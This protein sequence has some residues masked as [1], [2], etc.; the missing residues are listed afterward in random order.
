MELAFVLLWTIYLSRKCLKSCVWGG[1]ICK[2]FVLTIM[3]PLAFI[4][5]GQLSSLFN[6]G[7][8][9]E[10]LTLSNM[11]AYKD[12]GPKVLL[13]STLII[14]ICLLATV[15]CAFFPK[16][17]LFGFIH[18][19]LVLICLAVCLANPH[20][21][22]LNFGITYQTYLKQRSFSPDAKMS[23]LQQEL[24]GQD[25]TFNNDFDAEKI[26]DLRNKSIVVIFAEGFS[27]EW[28]DRFNSYKDLTPNLDR[29]LSESVYFD[30]YY[31]HTAATFRGLRGQLTSSYQYRGGYNVKNNGLGQ[32]N[33][34]N[35]KK[36]LKGR[37]ISVPQI[38]KANG[39]HSYFQSAHTMKYQL[40]LMLQTLDFDSVFGAEDVHGSG[41]D[42][43][44]Q[45]IFAA[46][47]GLIN[48][49]KLKKPYFLG[50]YTVGTHIGQNSSDVKYGDGNNVMLNTIRNFDDAFGKFWNSV[51]DRKD[52]VIIF[53][54]DHAAYPSDLYND[55]FKTK[56]EFFIDKIPFAVWGD[57]IKPDVLDAHGRNSLDFAPTLLQSMGIR[58]AFNYF[59]GCSLFS[60]DCPR[61][62][63]YITAIGDGF[64]QTPELRLL[65]DNNS[66][67]K[68]M[69]QKIRDFYNMS[70]DQHF[71]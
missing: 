35:I 20:G 56:R 49:D 45:Q 33:A 63:E 9:I 10:V 66:D 52:L 58:H 14:V 1:V 6:T 65:K 70:E 32:V 13:S 69:I 12:V 24:Y 19:P 30:N 34:E 48:K 55:T 50:A 8:Y 2:I 29:F 5:G 43:T 25:S 68:R 46:L 64:V 71:L 37:L 36:S 47:S 54:A 53:T 31:N 7:H 39:Y 21:A 61:Q 15:F 59:L 3:L 16:K 67:D 28:I 22:I 26:M 38:L 44:D 4:V 41:S 40:N 60:S 23:G 51:N 57:G 18:W 11:D 42:L 27:A 62:F 17:N